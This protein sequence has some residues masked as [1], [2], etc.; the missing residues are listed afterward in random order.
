MMLEEMSDD[1]TGPLMV[2]AKTLMRDS[3]CLDDLVVD[4]RI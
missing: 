4:F 1:I 3:Y 2:S